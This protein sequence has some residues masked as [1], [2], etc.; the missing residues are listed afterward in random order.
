ME[1]TIERVSSEAVTNEGGLSDSIFDK[2]TKRAVV[3]WFAGS[4]TLPVSPVL[5]AIFFGETV[6]QMR[7]ATK[8]K[9]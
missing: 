7:L 2:H 3:A 4:F 1:R 6:R 5:T 9:K 8:A